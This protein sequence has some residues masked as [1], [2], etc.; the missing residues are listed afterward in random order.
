MLT[1]IVLAANVDHDVEL[2]QDVF[3]TSPNDIGVLKMIC[4]LQQKTS[5]CFIAMK[6]SIVGTNLHHFPLDF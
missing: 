4:S 3:V 5:Q 2:L 1:W 6:T